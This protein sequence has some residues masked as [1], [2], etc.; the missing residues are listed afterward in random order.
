MKKLSQLEIIEVCDRY[1]RGDSSTLIAKDMNVSPVAI[2]GLLGRRG[3]ERR[4]NSEAARRYEMNHR[5]FQ[6]I[7][8]EVKAYW[9]GFFAADGCVTDDGTI[10][11]SLASQDEIHLHLF[12]K[13]ISSTHPVKQRVDNTYL[14]SSFNVYSPDMAKDLITLGITPRKTH[15]LRMPS[16]VGVGVD[17]EL[18][19]HF[20]RGYIDGDGGFY[21]TES[22]RKEPGYQFSVTSNETFILE[23]QDILCKELELKHTKTY[24]RNKL[25]AIATMSYCGKQQVAKIAKWV[26]KNTDLYL[27]RK[28][29]KIQN[30]L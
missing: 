27:E 23:L 14:S 29:S 5:F 30:I 21:I 9:L 28:R 11:V 10:R 25:S 18:A 4:S 6:Q 19:R 17:R 16:F 12:K 8:T 2:R 3:I 15:T 20:I 1:Q 22:R 7:D 13:A 24:R 26:Y